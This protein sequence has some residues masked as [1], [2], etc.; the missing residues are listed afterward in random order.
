VVGY[1]DHKIPIPKKY[2]EKKVVIIS[3]EKNDFTETM[4]LTLTT[5]G[6]CDGSGFFS[7]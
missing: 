6:L 2:K 7:S 4:M 1:F 3:N 5:K